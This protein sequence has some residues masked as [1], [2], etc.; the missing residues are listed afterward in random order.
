MLLIFTGTTRIVIVI[1]VTTVITMI[2]VISICIFFL[3]RSICIFLRV[4]KPKDSV[5]SKFKM[6]F[7][8]LKVIP[9][10][11]KILQL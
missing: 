8:I 2:L 9:V 4:R 7:V 6:S 3:R 5:E 10:C 11:Y 1:V